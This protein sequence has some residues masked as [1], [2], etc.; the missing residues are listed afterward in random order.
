MKAIGKSDDYNITLSDCSKLLK[1]A[2]GIEK[3]TIVFPIPQITE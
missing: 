3:I 1:A 2:L